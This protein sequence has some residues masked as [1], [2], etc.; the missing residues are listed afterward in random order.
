MSGPDLDPED[1]AAIMLKTGRRQTAA[2]R[3]GSEDQAQIDA[4]RR[5]QRSKV[6]LVQLNARVL[7][8]ARKTFLTICARHCDERGNALEQGIALERMIDFFKDKDLP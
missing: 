5:K 6:K 1:I 7:P 2:D 4:E 8:T 3:K